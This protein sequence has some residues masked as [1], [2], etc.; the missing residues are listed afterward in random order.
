MH[1]IKTPIHYLD[2]EPFTTADEER[3]MFRTLDIGMPNPQRFE[4]LT[5]HRGRG[6]TVEA[7]SPPRY[8]LSWSPGL[9]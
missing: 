8:S 2:N 1:L 6:R 4:P 5:T 9:R 3:G 7:P